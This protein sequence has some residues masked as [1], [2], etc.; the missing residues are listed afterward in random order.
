MKRAMAI[1]MATAM[2]F[3]L[4]AGCS[5]VKPPVD[6][7]VSP[8]SP[9]SDVKQ[10][11][12][13]PP[14]T[15][16]PQEEKTWYI[17]YF[18][19]LT[20]D[21]A[22]YGVQMT[23]GMNVKINDINALGG[24][25]GR[26]KVV[27]ETFDDKNTAAQ[28]ANAAQ[29]IVN[30][31]RYI[32][33]V[34]P[35]SSTC[36]MA[37]APVFESAKMVMFAP[38]P[39]HPDLTTK[40]QYVVRYVTPH[41]GE[42]G[43]LAKAA[44]DDLG[45]SKVAIVTANTDNGVVTKEI[46]LEEIAKRGKECVITESYNEGQ[47]RDFTPLLT[48]IKSAGAEVITFNAQYADMGAMVIQSKQLG[49]DDTKW[50][51]ARTVKNDDFIKLAGEAAEGVYVICDFFSEDPNPRVQEFVKKVMPL[52]DNKQPADFAANSYETMAIIADALEKG[53]DSRE[54]MYEA[55]INVK[56]WDGDTG[57]V[58]F[59]NRELNKPMMLLEIQNGKYVISE[60]SPKSE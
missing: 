38:T 19:P 16:K 44:M 51:G 3:I 15:E 18:G 53:A 2:L 50:V 32:V 57:Y 22:Q 5:N 10:A 26:E 52:M 37:A 46:L 35:F 48:R 7:S 6:A 41:K 30:D 58:T 59:V 28:A 4:V 13:T 40:H 56:E 54:S 23:A 20:G 43:A 36:A 27:L 9:S 29:L 47:V 24:I 8:A 33:G 14:K 34:G 60:H 39:A 55:L 21:A 11:T 31:E 49:M 42:I 45:F 12:E 25:R 17:P 1:L